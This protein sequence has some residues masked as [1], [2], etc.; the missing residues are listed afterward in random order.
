MNTFRRNNRLI[1]AIDHFT[2]CKHVHSIQVIW[3]DLDNSPPNTLLE[4]P[5]VEVERHT[6]NSLNNRFKALLP[7]ETEAVFSVDDDLF[8]DCDTLFSAFLAWKSSPRAL[9]GFGPRAGVYLEDEQRF[10]YKTQWWTWWNGWYN[11]ILTKAC[12]MHRDY[13]QGLYMETVPNEFLDYIDLHKNCEDIAMQFV[14]SKVSGTAPLWVKGYM[15]DFGGDG[16]SS[17]G[18]HFEHRSGCID[19]LVDGFKG[20]PLVYTN[21]FILPG[22]DG[23]SHYV[24]E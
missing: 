21:A 11:I 1:R 13:V 15:D 3:S 6:V 16:I 4:Y 12:F 7:I 14:V 8:I 22:S 23:W 10:Q 17:G 5:K 9:V 19:R 2:Q 18:G 24:S 20:N